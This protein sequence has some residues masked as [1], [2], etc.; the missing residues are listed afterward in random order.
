MVNLNLKIRRTI[1]MKESPPRLLGKEGDHEVCVCFRHA[2]LAAM[3]GKKV[4]E[5]IDVADSEYDSR[6]WYCEICAKEHKEDD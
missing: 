6:P 4:T 3:E 2:V 1:V 5:E